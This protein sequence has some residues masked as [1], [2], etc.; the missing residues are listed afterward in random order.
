MDVTV[1]AEVETGGAEAED[2]S[3]VSILYATEV[4]EPVGDG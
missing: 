3:S 4:P 1:E 2:G